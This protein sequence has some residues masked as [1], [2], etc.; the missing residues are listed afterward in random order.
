[1]H[2]HVDITSQISLNAQAE[3]L[4]AMMIKQQ[5]TNLAADNNAILKQQQLLITCVQTRQK[6]PQDNGHNM[7]T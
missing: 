1:V 5:V 2:G 7:V 6:V 4:L 3:E